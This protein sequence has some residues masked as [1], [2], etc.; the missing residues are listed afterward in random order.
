MYYLA[1]KTVEMGNIYY[2][3]YLFVF[4]FAAITLSVILRKKEQKT[5]E[6]VIAT[7]LWANFALHF[8]KLLIPPYYQSLPYSINESTFQNICA[9]NT[10]IF[11]FIFIKR[12]RIFIDYMIYVGLISGLAAVILP[13]EALGKSPFALDTLRFYFCHFTVGVAPLLIVITKIH[14]V[15]YHNIWKTAFVLYLVLGIIIVNEVIL[16]ELGF[17]SLRGDNL[18][19]PDYR[20]PSLIFGPPVEIIG[21]PLLKVITFWTPKVFLKIPVGELAGEAKYWPFFWL[22]IP[23]FVY[24]SIMAFCLSLLIDPM[25]F[26]ND[27]KKI[28]LRFKTN[29]LN[30]VSSS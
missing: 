29:N 9:V 15:N 20:N 12:N 6:M 17:V 24:F 26:F 21:T 1:S 3:I 4:I 23:S 16:M 8:L 30:K 28:L 25:H 7:L 22:A 2:F 11:P 5:Q 27:I 10:L 13:T 14:S 18:L 19:S